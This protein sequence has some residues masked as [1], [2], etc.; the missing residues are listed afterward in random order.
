MGLTG[1][2]SIASGGGAT[3]SVSRTALT[4][5]RTDDADDGA[6]AGARPVASSAGAAT[7]ADGWSDNTSGPAAVAGAPLP[8]TGAT[9][10]ASCCSGC[11][12]CCCAW[13]NPKASVQTA[14]MSVTTFGKRI[15]FSL[16]IVLAG[17]RG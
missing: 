10:S 4:G 9:G 3:G 2:S 6:G 5:G 17:G 11:S 16:F 8:G 13:A 15:A 7:L 14:R 1:W 12:G